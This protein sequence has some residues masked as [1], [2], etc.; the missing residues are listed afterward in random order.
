M[1]ENQLHLEKS[2]YLRQHA[3]NPVH[4]HPYGEQA[5]GKA[6]ELNKLIFLSIG[7]SSCHWCHVMAH[8]SFEDQT[9]ANYLNEH[10][11]S[12]KVDREEYPDLDH[13]FQI[14]CSLVTGR[15]GWP[16][17]VFLT[18][19]GKPF[20]AGTYF[21]KLGREG[22]PSFLEVSQQI[23]NLFRTNPAEVNQKASGLEAEILKPIKQE[24]K[25]EFQGHFPA[26]SAIMNALKN[27]ADAPNGGY[28]KAPKFPH[29]AFYEW[30]CEQIL[31][32]MIPKDQG[33]HI[34]ET[35]K[36]MMMGGMYDHVKGGIHRYSTDDKFMIPHFEKMLY[37]QA[38]L[39]KLLAKLSQFYPAPLIFD[40]ILQTLDYL[41][42]E[43]LSEEGHFFSA[44]D[45]DSEGHEGLYFTFSQEEFEASFESAPPE[46]RARIDYYLKVFNITEKGNF[47]HGLNVIS[48]NP[49][50]KNQY[51][52]QD[53]WQ[54]IREIKSRLLEQRKL[55]MP[56]ATDRKGVAGWNYQLLSAL[57]DIIQYCPVD[58]IQNEALN[59]IQATVE[60]CLKQFI[61]KDADRHVLRHV[62]TLENQAL[63]L[64]DYVNFCEA[65]LRLY[66]ITGN[67]TFKKNG[68]ESLDFTLK[69]FI[70]EDGEIMVTSLHKQTPGVQNIPT[71]LYDQSYRS[72]AMVLILLLSR[73]S[74]FNPELSPD[75][76]LKE[77]FQDIAQFVLSN[78]LGHGEGLRALIYPLNI[79]RRV[80]VP[81]SWIENREFLEM[82][83]HFFSRFVMDYQT[84]DDESY[85]ICTKEACEV[86]GKGLDNFKELFQAKDQNA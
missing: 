19:E 29:F 85:Q 41:K 58:V 40:G 24:K 26:P 83:S 76:V 56:P 34:V 73:Y 70:R 47:T 25:I 86:S 43:M 10:F 14:A 35:V 4:W 18:P 59:L 37:D 13:Y 7:Y 38:G 9:T 21:P 69:N 63:Y 3:E 50:L 48:L 65:Q 27:F 64:E 55:R 71:P 32:G 16:L 11:I 42:N 22:M 39:L 5:L 75:I 23:E 28:G 66:E 33:Q 57:T 78:P 46:Q 6:K 17:N 20:F 15:G 36:R 45:A 81:R 62:S 72:S 8:E 60:G 61:T 67:E 84:S 1:S 68:L 79:F 80:E 51:Y 54:E 74:V 52:S 77:K 31:E 49:E 30:A 82:R 2:L 12:I 44:Q 53:G